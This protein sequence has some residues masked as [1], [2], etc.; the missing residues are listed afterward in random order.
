VS[1]RIPVA[2]LRRFHLAATLTWLVLVVPSL[3]WWKDSILWVIILSVWAN[4]ASH[5]GAWQAARAEGAAD[6]QDGPPAEEKRGGYSGSMDA[7]DVPPPARIRS[8]S[9]PERGRNERSGG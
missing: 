9:M 3:I 1:R 8:A 5:F 7:A 2:W 4:V 6:A